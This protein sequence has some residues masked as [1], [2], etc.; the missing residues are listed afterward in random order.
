MGTTASA[1]A[2]DDNTNINNTN[3]NNFNTDKYI[4]Q[5]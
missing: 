3:P 1:I 5:R 4:E 2:V